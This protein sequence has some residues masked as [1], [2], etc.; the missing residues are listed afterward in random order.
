V[1]G[2]TDPVHAEGKELIPGWT[3][4]RDSFN[5]GVSFFTRHPSP[6]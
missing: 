3:S 2:E 5:N 6:R 1:S 4:G